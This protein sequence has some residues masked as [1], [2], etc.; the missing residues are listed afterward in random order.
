VF[1]QDW[2]ATRIPMLA[3]PSDW[4]PFAGV[5]FF[6]FFVNTPS[7]FGLVLAIAL[8]VD[9]AI[10][11]VEGKQRHMQEACQVDRKGMEEL[12]GLVLGA[13]LVSRADAAGA[14]KAHMRLTTQPAA[15]LR[16]L[17]KLGRCPVL[18]C[19]LKAVSSSFWVRGPSQGNGQQR[20]R[21]QTA[22]AKRMQT[23]WKLIVLICAATWGEKHYLSA[24]QSAAP[25]VDGTD[26]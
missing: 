18:D 4:L 6:D 10:V 25:Q 8:V 23:T 16:R 2:R 5:P 24:L 17:P 1:L 26:V 13:A 3:V 9:D 20:A 14:T 7:P 12:T 19:R 15:S 11:L 22:G 21:H